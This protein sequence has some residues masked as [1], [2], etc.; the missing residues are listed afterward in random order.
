MQYFKNFIK[1]ISLNL[2]KNSKNTIVDTRGTEQVLRNHI[3]TFEKDTSTKFKLNFL[4]IGIG[5][6]T[7]NDVNLTLTSKGIIFAF[8]LKTPNTV[9]NKIKA[10]SV[11]FYNFNVFS[12]LFDYLE[13]LQHHRA[14]DQS[15]EK[16][17]G[18]GRILKIF[19]HSKFDV[20][21]G[22]VVEKGL[23]KIGDER[24]RVF[25]ND[26]QIGDNLKIKSLKRE[27][28]VIKLATVNQEFGIIFDNFIDLE[29]GDF[30]EQ[31]SVDSSSEK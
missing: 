23:I 24:F 31:F 20:I 1:S 26:Q 28:E 2:P 15:T 19:R 25:R 8:N 18:K 6:P 12:H 22:C 4:H 5:A 13:K 14:I 27:K 21:A 10:N 9:V 29:V 11:Q 3:T 16:V 30:I 17:V 7:I